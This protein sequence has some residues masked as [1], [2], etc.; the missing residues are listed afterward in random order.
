METSAKLKSMD[1]TIPTKIFIW[2][3]EM[4]ARMVGATDSVRIGMNQ[5]NCVGLLCYINDEAIAEKIQSQC[6]VGNLMNYLDE[7][8]PDGKM[9]LSN[10]ECEHLEKCWNN[11]DW[12]TVIKYI[13]KYLAI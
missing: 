3:D 7:H 8:R 13:R 4:A 6:N 11:K 2:K 1:K 5:D 12:E 9:C 10:I